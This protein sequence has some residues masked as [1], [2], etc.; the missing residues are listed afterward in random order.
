MFDLDPDGRAGARARGRPRPPPHRP[1]RRQPDRAT[2]SPR[3]WPRWS[4]PRRGSRCGRATSAT[5]AVERRRAL[6]RRASPTAADRRRGDRAR[7]RRRRGALAADHQPARGDRRRPGAGG[8][9]RAPTSPTSSSASSTRPRWRCRAPRFD[10]VL[11]T[12]AIRGEGATLLDAAG[13]ALH[14]RARAARRGH[15]GD[16]RPDARPTARR[17]VTLD[18]REID[19]PA[20]PT[21][22]PRSPRPASTPRAEP[23]PVA[24]AAH[25]TMGGDRRRPR[26]PLL[27][28]RPLRRR[29]V[30]LHRPARRQP[31][32]LEL[33]QRVL[34][35]RRPRRRARRVE[36]TAAATAR[37]LPDWRFEPPDRGD[38][39]R[40][41]GASPGRC[42]TPTTCCA[43]CS[44]TPTRSRG[45][46]A[47]AR[48]GARAS[49]AA[50]TCAPTSR[51]TDPAL[52]GIH[53]VARPDGE[54]RREEWR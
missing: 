19:P 37:P 32:R 9:R 11:I 53:F 15:R 22:S 28:A 35:L 2:R 46:I 49:R 44:P 50:A 36:E 23:V 26:R 3:S 40:A 7:D 42:A 20:S 34:R 27:A 29:R 17:S 45:A 18:L 16:P 10:G 48:P 1:R 43:S 5:G 13:R 41:S 24:P 38:P 54:V 31:A 47:T 33:A 12:E 6:P 14:R 25:Y 51:E 4:P 8:D 21:S 30:L 39:R 52:D